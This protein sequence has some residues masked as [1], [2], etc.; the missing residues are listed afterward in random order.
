MKLP[1]VSYRECGEHCASTVRYMLRGGWVGL[2]QYLGDLWAR[3][4]KR[5]YVKIVFRNG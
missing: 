5:I 4:E 1:E 3:F 2:L